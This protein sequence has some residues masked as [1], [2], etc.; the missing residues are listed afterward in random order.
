MRD[1]KLFPFVCVFTGIFGV[2]KVQCYLSVQVIV[3]LETKFFGILLLKRD[4]Q[5]ENKGIFHCNYHFHETYE[6][7][8][9]YINNL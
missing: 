8:Q 7:T 4:H 3:S 5:K 9:L 2:R 6:L 1:G